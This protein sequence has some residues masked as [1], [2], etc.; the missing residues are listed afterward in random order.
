MGLLKNCSLHEEK[1]GINIFNNPVLMSNNVTY[2]S[3]PKVLDA[4]SG[5]R[6]DVGISIINSN[7]V[8]NFSTK[9]L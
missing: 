3:Q 8:L 9:K 5:Y 7:V 1:R 4:E 2:T 6:E